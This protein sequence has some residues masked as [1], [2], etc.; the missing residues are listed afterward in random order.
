MKY[1]AI[2]KTTGEVTWDAYF[3]YLRSIRDRFPAELY[4]YAIDWG[5]YSLDGVDS[6][7]DSWLGSV[8]IGYRNR[9]ITLEFLGARHD[10]KHCFTYAEV[11]QYRM[12]LEV[13]YKRGDRDVLMHE[14]TMNEG[15]LVHEIVFSNKSAISINAATIV[16]RTEVLS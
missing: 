13:T 7:H 6:L 15:R 11:D 14:F 9:E 5:H 16:P 8:Q 12:D 4:A 2:D 10:R 1:V 3:A